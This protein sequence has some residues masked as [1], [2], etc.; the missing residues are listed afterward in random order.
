VRLVTAVRLCQIGWAYF[1]TL[2]AEKE[3]TVFLRFSYELIRKSQKW[4]W[5]VK[6]QTTAVKADHY[7]IENK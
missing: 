7:E 5:D 2:N 1:G 6:N 3:A 4:K